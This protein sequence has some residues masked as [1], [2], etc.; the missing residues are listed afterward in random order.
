MVK[1]LLIVN[2]AVFVAQIIYKNSQTMEHIGA[3][4]FEW[5]ILKGQI[6]RFVTYQYLHGSPGHLLWNMLGLY[7]LGSLMEGRWG[8][9]KFLLLYTLFGAAGAM[10]FAV[11]VGSGVLPRGDWMIGASGSVL[12]L[13]GACAIAVPQ[14]RLLLFF[15]I[16]T[17]AIIFAVLIEKTMKKY[18][19]E[20]FTHILNLSARNGFVFLLFAL[21]YTGALIALN[22]IDALTSILFIWLFSIAVMYGS[23]AYYFKK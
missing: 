22:L 20:R 2:V 19:D 6:W 21:P 23:G 13:V 15:P 9:R 17:V 11:L 5:A 16:R 12:G 7:F 3:F 8:R 10:L 14:V 1:K 4:V 18:R